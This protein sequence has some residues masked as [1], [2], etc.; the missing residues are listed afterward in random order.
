MLR[1][2]TEVQVG[3]VPGPEPHGNA[4]DLMQ[5]VIR[6]R[7]E[8]LLQAL[9]GSPGE[10]SSD[11]VLVPGSRRDGIARRAQLFSIKKCHAVLL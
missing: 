10:L 9:A 3:C 1:I 5:A 8:G 4:W 2:E 6:R 11:A 7:V